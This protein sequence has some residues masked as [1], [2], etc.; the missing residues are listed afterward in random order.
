MRELKIAFFDTKPYDSKSFDN[1]NKSYGFTIK[2]FSEKLN[3][4]TAP[5]A[6]GYDAVC[7]FVNDD[8]CASTLEKL[9][10]SGIK[11]IAL[12]CA[13]Y[14]NVDLR[15]SFGKIH[16]VRVPDYSPYAVAEHATAL[17]LSL[18]R[19]IHRA[20]YRVRDNNYSINGLLGFDMHGKTAGVIGTGKIGLILIKILRGFGMNVLASDLHPNEDAARELGFSYTSLDDLYA[21]SDIISLHCPLN[22]ETYHLINEAAIKK[23]KK[24]VMLINT[25]RGQLIDTAALVEGLK[26]GM[27]GFAGL[28]VYEEESEY[29]FEDKSDE[30]IVDDVLARLNT[31]NNVLVTSHQAFFTKEALENISATTLKNINLFFNEGSLP[32]EICYKCGKTPC[33]RKDKPLSGC[34]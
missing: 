29:F 7:A 21:Q 20:Y 30:I 34:F 5:L 27:V 33:P 8:L 14:N 11:L 4:D 10:A 22:A 23:M 17:M 16:I 1:A 26:S 13:G 28:D 31:F 25:G 24:G 2:Y 19:K 9:N 32:N 15:E 18:N 12:R 3:P 6:S